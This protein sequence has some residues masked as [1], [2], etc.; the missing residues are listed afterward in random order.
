M[1]FPAF[2]NLLARKTQPSEVYDKYEPRFPADQNAVDLV[3]GWSMGFPAHLALSAGAMALFSDPRMAWAIEHFGDL[4]GRKVLELGPLEGGHTAM[5]HSAG[6]QIEAIEA[7]KLAFMRCLITKEVLKLP[8][9]S[10]RLGDFVKWLDQPGLAYDFIV[11]S[12]VL[13]H[14]RDPLGFLEAICEKTTSVYIWT[15]FIADD[16]PPSKVE[17]FRGIPVRLYQ[18]PYGPGVTDDSFCGG[19]MDKPF[20]IFRDDILAA[21]KALGFL[22]IQTAHEESS[23]HGPGFSIFARK[24][25]SASV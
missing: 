22:E 25:G 18:R 6:A 2:R 10:F 24:S 3:P 19:L 9:A 5:L 16:R 8:N 17:V 20:W 15:V 12:G 14:L 11:A 7:N 1:R 23:I 13:Y 21:L 4:N